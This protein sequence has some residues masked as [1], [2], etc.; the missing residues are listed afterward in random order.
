[1]HPGY[2]AT[3]GIPLLSGRS[4]AA[5]D[6]PESGKT[7][8]VNEAF[9]RQ[10]LAG[11]DPVGQRMRFTR[12]TAAAP[13][14]IIGVVGNARHFRLEQ[15]AQPEVYRPMAQAPPQMLVL[16]IRT[17]GDPR[18]A[19]SLLRA[20]I[21]EVDRDLP[22]EHLM[23][24]DGLVGRTIAERRFYLLLMA[25]FSGVAVLLAVV[26]IYGVMA[27]AVGQR[28]REIGIRLALGAAPAHVQRMVLRA[29]A[30]L[31]GIGLLIGV[32]GALAASSVLRSQLF[33]VTPRDPVTLIAVI[34]ILGGL[35]LAATYV[36]ARR[37]RLLDPIAALRR[38]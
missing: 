33:G 26:G 25:F 23:T 35:G 30:V 12:E 8:V 10:H 28:T 29:G 19:V 38:E 1:V 5:E 17:S 7:V 36:P 21:R 14:Q 11:L 9:A 34:G 24:M 31:I 20:A 4:F 37:A 16:A 15:D 13:V 3:L 22:V 6:S 32:I 18:G 2:F 27:Q